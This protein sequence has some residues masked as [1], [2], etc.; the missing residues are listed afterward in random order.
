MS[1]AGLRGVAPA[2]QVVHGGM[3][4]VVPEGPYLAGPVFS[5]PYHS[6]GDPSASA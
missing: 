4:P 5:A 6:P 2:T 1:D 3:A